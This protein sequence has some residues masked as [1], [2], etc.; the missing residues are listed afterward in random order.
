MQQEIREIRFL[1]RVIWMAVFIGRFPQT[2]CPGDKSNILDSLFLSVSGIVSHGQK[3]R[4]Y[5][6]S[7]DGGTTVKKPGF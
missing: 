3:S 4:G 2:S 5:H 1:H 7:T 6:K